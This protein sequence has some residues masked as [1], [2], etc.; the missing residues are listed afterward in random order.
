[1]FF[2]FVVFV[3][4][5]A[6]LAYVLSEKKSFWITTVVIAVVWS[7]I[8]HPIWGAV[9]FAEM[10]IGYFIITQVFRAGS[11]VSG[12]VQGGSVESGNN[13]I[14]SAIMPTVNGLKKLSLSLDAKLFKFVKDKSLRLIKENDFYES[15]LSLRAGM[16][17]KEEKVAVFYF[18]VRGVV[19]FYFDEY[20]VVSN[21]VYKKADPVVDKLTSQLLVEEF[22]WNNE[23]ILSSI[24]LKNDYKKVGK[25]FSHALWKVGH[26]L[27]VSE[28]MGLEEDLQLKI[29]PSLRYDFIQVER[30]YESAKARLLHIEALLLN[31]EDYKLREFL[32]DISK[33]LGSI[34]FKLKKDL[35]NN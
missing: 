28:L 29:Y 26:E 14:E 5:G 30:E 4:I 23:Q 16:G 13:R 33:D 20:R 32:F 24:E 7:L 35:Y 8:N 6:F 12:G 27:A 15:I 31:I 19:N 9:S 10:L 2:Y 3:S 17:S 25:S 34:D 1:M 11:M 21:T 22:G 18:I